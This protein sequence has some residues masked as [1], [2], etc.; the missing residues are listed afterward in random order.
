MTTQNTESGRGVDIDADENEWLEDIHG[1]KP[2][3]WIAAQNERT[4]KMLDTPDFTRTEARI[5]EVLDSTDRIPM[6]SS[7]G[8]YLYNF[9]K[10]AEHPRG[11]WR[12]TTPES[13]KTDA[14]D[15]EIL[16]DVDQLCRDE[17]AEWVFSGAQSLFPDYTRALIS[18][19]PDGGDAVTIR[20]FDLVSKQFVGDGFVLPAA[21][22]SVSW[23]D[24]DTVF[25]AT[26]FGPGSMTTSSYPR[27]VKRWSRGQVLADAELVFEVPV[28]HMT[29]GADHDHTVGF[30]RDVVVDV[31][32]FHHSRAYVLQG[33]DLVHIDVP[34]DASVDL[35]REWVLIRPR[36]YWEM[37]GATF[38]AGA[39]LVTRLDA[40]LAGERDLEA[41]FTPDERTSLEN[42]SWTRHHLLL[43]MLHDVS[44]RIEVVTPIG[45]E[46]TH[47]ALAGAPALHTV[48]AAGVDADENDDYWLVDTGYLTPSSLR[49]GTIGH[50]DPALLKSSP[51]FFD[52]SLYAVEQHFVASK[53][54]TRVPYFQ[55]SGRDL[56]LDG[57]NPT[58]LYGYGGFEIALTPSYSGS[59]GR[60]WLERGGV[61]VVANIRGGGE[62]GPGWHYAALQKNRPRAYE[63]FSAVAEDL[64]ARGVTSPAHLGCEG[65]SNGGLLVGNML[66]HYPHLFGAIVCEVPLLDMKRYTKLSAGASWM[67]EYGDPEDPAQWAFIETFSPY[68]NLSEGNT[69]PPVLFYTATSDDRVGPVQA[70][71][72]AARMQALGIPGVWFYENREGGHG[73]AADNKQSAHLHASAYEFLWDRLNRSAQSGEASLRDE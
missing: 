50:A 72:M 17:D 7:R 41:L 52:E 51:S 35:H 15:W 2:L 38:P 13:Y 23:I 16:L 73:A 58:L 22:T 70:R 47:Q 8:G 29:V 62:Y 9:W 46:W 5:L 57:S 28:D 39:L 43:T 40:Y 48:S 63:D 25:V 26:D 24:L 44:S 66:T 12:R 59:V 69:Y 34:D 49:L 37:G 6:V 20:E 64:I 56:T 31:I 71:K 42:W 4:S 3:A 19:S 1:E 45:G 68:H 60:S 10:D 53:D 11:L 21:K 18:L 65:G 14:P 54:G 32:D 36:T 33:D 55:V 30:E 61:Y 67:A 27:Q